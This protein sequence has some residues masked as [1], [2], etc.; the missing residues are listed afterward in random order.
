MTKKVY[1]AALTAALAL[2]MSM[3]AFAAGWQKS[4]NDWTYVN[5]SGKRVT[6]EWQRGADNE[7]RWINSQGVM[8]T[9][10][11]ADNEYYVDGDGKIVVNKWMKLA[12]KNP[13][14]NQTGQS[15]WYYFGNSGKCVTGGWSKINNKYYY[16]NDDGE[17]QTG[18]VDDEQY[19]VNGDGVMQTG[20]VWLEDPDKKEEDSTAPDIKDDEDFHWYY[21]KSNGKKF[22]PEGSGYQLEKIDGKYFC[23][24]DKGA[25]QT[26]WVNMGDKDAG[27]FENMRYFKSDGSVMTKWAML[28]PPDDDELDGLMKLD[29]YE[30]QWYYFDSKG[31]PEVGP[32]ISNASTNNL[33][34]INGVTY[35][36][37][38]K[39][40][41]VYGLRKL[42]IG[43]RDEYAAY[44][45]GADKAT[46]SVVCG[47]GTVEE[48]DGSKHEYY[49][50]E[51]GN[52]KG[53]GFTGV[54]NKYLYY[55]GR[56]Q[57]ATDNNAAIF[58]I[59]GKNYA[60]NRSG[61]VLTKDTFKISGTKYKTNANGI[62]CEVDGESSKGDE[63]AEEPVEPEFWD[64]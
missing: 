33:K 61:K 50:N 55:M 52:N 26:G 22:E 17:M 57:Q 14:W 12:I 20:W 35:L 44:F 54:K 8:A 63:S 48:G 37:N 16:F 51:T 64:D 49:F 1:A 25:M 27:S 31:V 38:D 11:W 45:F 6:N 58:A 21:F 19:Y 23:F 56:L 36:F 2:G 59:D 40:N 3:T 30:E 24:N 46:S 29:D 41:P 62:I 7:W 5:D 13:D 18:W 10:S 39:G 47:K 32:E 28:T 60:V 9:N 53:R 42:R 15:A 4:G 43:N 34:K